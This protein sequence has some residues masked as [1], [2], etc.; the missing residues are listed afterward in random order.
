MGMFNGDEMRRRLEE[1]LRRLEL[2][3]QVQAKMQ[4]VAHPL[5]PQVNG[6]QQ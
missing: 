2:Q 1:N 4:E 6:Q 3:A 5:Q